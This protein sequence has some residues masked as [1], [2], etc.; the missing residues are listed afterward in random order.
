MNF[1]ECFMR[2]VSFNNIC[3]IYET[4][5][6]KNKNKNKNKNMDNKTLITSD[7]KKVQ[8]FM[9]DEKLN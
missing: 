9:G 1:Y 6:S 8:W 5:K 4:N 3:P 7:P 2:C